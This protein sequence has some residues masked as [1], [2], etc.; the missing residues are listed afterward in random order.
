M[1]RT[2]RVGVLW[3]W[4]ILLAGPLTA[5]SPR[6]EDSD[7]ITQCWSRFFP[8]RGALIDSTRADSAQS[9]S[10]AGEVAALSVK[11]NGIGSLGDEL[12][13]AVSD[14]LPS[15]AGALGF[16]QATTEDG[17]ASFEKNLLL[18]F[19]AKP[20]RFRIRALLRAPAIYS[21]L[22]DTLTT[23]GLTARTDAL[24]KKLRDYDDARLSLAW[25]LENG[26]F[27]RSFEEFRLGYSRLFDAYVRGL[28]TTERNRAVSAMVIP[29]SGDIRAD[30][31]T[32]PSCIDPISN[33]EKEDVR[34]DCLKP[35]F[36]R[37][38]I[39]ALEDAARATAQ[40]E[41]SLAA[42]LKAGGFH[43][44]NDLIDNQPQLS[45]EAS[46]DIRRDLVG[47]NEF[48]VSVRYEGG[49]ANVNGLRQYC[50]SKGAAE[51]TPECLRQYLESPGVRPTLQRSDRFYVVAEFS[52]RS[53]FTLVVP[54]DSLR[55]RA[56]GTWDLTGTAG[57]GRY[58]AF[59]RSGEGVGRLD[60]AAEY[61]HHQDDPLRANR[62]VITGTYTQRLNGSLSVAAGFSYS[63]R[64]EFVGD[65]DKK[66]SANFGLRYKLTKE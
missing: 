66:V 30:R 49:F 2:R 3:P 34:L 18:P 21:P 35:D 47:P 46:T 10:T 55:L 44:F 1:S 31:L 13:S 4:L 50:R 38:V 45:L 28:N 24:G 33:E 48:H 16:T 20:Q 22:A 36:R 12:A 54:E 29:D 37:T 23:L 11:N 43:E 62:L 42:E 41:A 15:I 9:A 61:V 5:Q 27:G 65:V 14:F 52:R 53:D 51:F 25:N 6:C 19:G 26:T 32:D 58:V 39:M 40:V 7:T 63:N 64:P 56:K 57:V 8:R 59:D 60:L 17:S